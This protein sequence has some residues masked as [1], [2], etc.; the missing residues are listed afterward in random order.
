MAFG[1]CKVCLKAVCVHCAQDTGLGLGCSDTC[2]QEIA[3]L[4]EI[5][6]K[7]KKVYSIGKNPR[8]LNTSVLVYGFL[9]AVFTIMGL[10]PLVLG[11]HPEPLLA[12]MGCGFLFFGVLTFIRNRR[13]N[14]SI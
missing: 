2:V 13:L 7:N 8:L 6:E 1:L 10:L 11:E 4:N 5:I 14:I 9:G 3:E 12:I